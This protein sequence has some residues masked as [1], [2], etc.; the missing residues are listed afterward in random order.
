MKSFSL[1]KTIFNVYLFLFIFTMTNKEFLFFGYDLRY[2]LVVIALL[3]ILLRFTL[4]KDNNKYSFDSSIKR[5]LAFYTYALF[6]TVFW[7]FNSLK[8]YDD[9]LFKNEVILVFNVFLAFIVFDMYKRYINEKIVS[10]FLIFSIL[11][12]C[13]SILLVKIGFSLAQISG[14]PEGKYIYGSAGVV[15]DNITA[16]GG[17]E[18]IGGYASDPNYATLLLIIGLLFSLKNIKEKK[19]N[20]IF[21]LLMIISIGLAF[22]KTVMIGLVI[23]IFVLLLKRILKV[24]EVIN[25]LIIA[26]ILLICFISPFIRS[27]YNT[28]SSTLTTRLCMWRSAF[29]LFKRNIVFGNGLTAFRS[30][31]ELNGGW[32]VQAHSTYWQ[33]LSELGLFGFALYIY[34][35]Y[36][37]MNCIRDN[38]LWVLFFIYI[39]WIMT[40][41]SIAMQFNVFILYLMHVAKD[42]SISEHILSDEK[43]IKSKKISDDRAMI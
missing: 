3:L 12:L 26:V 39:I 8:M 31:F 40:C 7:F 43:I 1:V 23:S 20:I 17:Y 41:E 2:S 30:Y 16:F 36:K 38:Y 15:S 33:V 13:G 42:N 24:N 11:V 9:Q 28:L 32:Y 5:I 29:E 35:L 18:R 37:S 21:I 6:S 10:R 27:F 19:Y 25:F 34:N 22:S 14:N 4:A